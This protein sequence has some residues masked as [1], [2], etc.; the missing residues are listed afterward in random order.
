MELKRFEDVLSFCDRTQDYLLQQEVAHNLQLRLCRTLVRNEAHYPQPPYLAVVESGSAIAAV[1]MRTPPFPLLLSEVQAEGAIALI[2]RD[3]LAT[4]PDLSGVNG[5]VAVSTAF[6]QTWQQ[7]TGQPFNL[8]MALRIHQLQQVRAMAMAQGTLRLAT[9]A[10]RDLLLEWHQD[11]MQ[12]ACGDRIPNQGSERWVETALRQ[13]SAHL[14]VDQ[15]PVSLAC[16]LACTPHSVVLNMVYT[17]PRYRQRGY[18]S[19]CVSSLSQ[20]LLAQG[21]RQCVLFTDLANPTSNKI[22]QA[23]GYEPVCDWSHYR[24]QG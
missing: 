2:A 4:Q 8:E 12:E 22:Y 19:A 6:A 16:S 21:Y 7:L 14:W 13:R 23:I 24:F 18:A 3:V 1:A 9:E 5:P 11:F 15:Q 17:P 10:D 20:N